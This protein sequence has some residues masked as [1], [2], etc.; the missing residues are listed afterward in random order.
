[1]G[2]ILTMSVPAAMCAGAEQQGS[3]LQENQRDRENLIEQYWST[4]DTVPN[5]RMVSYRICGAN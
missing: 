4:V 5:F 3:L 1:M 2:E